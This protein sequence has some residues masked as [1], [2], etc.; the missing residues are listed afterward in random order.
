MLL[1]FVIAAALCAVLI[2]GPRQAIWGLGVR[3]VQVAGALA[4]M[5]GMG[6]V[7]T[8]VVP[9]VLLAGL[10]LAGFAALVIAFVYFFGLPGGSGSSAAQAT[11]LNPPKSD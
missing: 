11:R 5:L 1:A 8:Y 4:V 9:F 7:M 2:V 3:V 10:C 6:I